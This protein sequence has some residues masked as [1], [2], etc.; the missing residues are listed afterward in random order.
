MKQKH[1]MYWIT[2]AGFV[3]ILFG[4]FYSLFG[5]EGLPV[6]QRFVPDASLQGWS[7][8][9]YGSVFIGFSVLLLLLGRR[10]IKQQDRDL[11][12]ILFYGVAAWIAYEALASL[13][14]GVYINVLVDV[15][16]IAFLGYPLLK[17]SQK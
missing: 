17:G 16:L 14:Y 3:G 9:L 2:I 15:A 1:F 5:L 12:K 4:I 11:G 7:R 10:A 8:G 13:I 6:Y